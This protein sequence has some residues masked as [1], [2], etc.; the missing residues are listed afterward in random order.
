MAPP[1][2]PQ[3]PPSGSQSHQP[4]KTLT[5]ATPLP[6]S[7]RSDILEWALP[8][9]F[10]HYVLT[11]KSRA[12]W[13]TSFVIPQLNLLLDA[14][15]VVNNNRPKHIFITHGH[16]DHALLSP[17]FIKR[18]DPPDFHCPVGMKQ[19][20]EDYLRAN[21]MLNLGGLIAPRP[22]KEV[23]LEV[24]DAETGEVVKSEIRPTHVTYGLEPGDVVPLRRTKN[25]S[26]V[27]FGCD[28]TV[29]CLGY[30]FQQ[31]THKLRP[32]FAK[33]PPK[34]LKAIRA[35]GQELTAPVTIPIFAF[36]G[37]TT[38]KTLESEPMKG[39]LENDKLPVV[40]TECSFLYE[41]HRAQAE[42]TKHT[43]WGDLE[44][45]VR[46]YPGTT[47][48]VMHFSLRYSVG[49]VRRFFKERAE[50]LANVVVWVDG[51][52]EDGDDVGGEGEVGDED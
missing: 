33:L 3:Q 9:P 21:T 43:I 47:F 19:V 25:I 22:G 24:R 12:A 26:A 17:V 42:K 4:T 41:E 10:S 7:T 5:F 46:R 51:E 14:G 37:D 20:L 6:Q 50:G 2:P 11:G 28:H 30:L 18:E 32:E 23:P 16:N 15:L 45:V 44:K 39:W 35:S 52:G 34:E 40:I 8:K 49:Q 31:T 1:P 38:T 48:V 27:A 29:P 13:H 36:L